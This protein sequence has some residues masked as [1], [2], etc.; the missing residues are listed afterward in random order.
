MLIERQSSALG[1]KFGERILVDLEFT[2]CIFDRSAELSLGRN[3]E[4]AVFGDE[5]CAS[6]FK[7]A[8]DLV[9]LCDLVWI[10]I[11]HVRL[12]GGLLVRKTKD[13]RMQRPQRRMQHAQVSRCLLVG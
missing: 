1:S 9:D 12:S 13:E 3:V 11:I 10:W 2:A 4:T 5:N 7:L 6:G 8:G